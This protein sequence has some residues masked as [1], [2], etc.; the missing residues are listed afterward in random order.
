MASLFGK[1]RAVSGAFSFR[2]IFRPPT[3]SMNILAVRLMPDCACRPLRWWGAGL[4]A[5]IK[6]EMD[7]A[8]L[9]LRGHLSV[10]QCWAALQKIPDRRA[11]PPR[12]VRCSVS[13]AA[14]TRPARSPFCSR[15]GFLQC[16]PSRSAAAAAAATAM[17][18]RVFGLSTDW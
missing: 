8:R 16:A 15:R 6:A 4:M 17:A 9:R 12:S 2:R 18:A 13:T 11:L 10:A 3:H 5:T 1:L 7:E 14:Q